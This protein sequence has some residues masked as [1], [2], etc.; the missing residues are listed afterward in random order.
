MKKLIYTFLLVFTVSVTSFA[1]LW[2]QG[3]ETNET[4]QF[5][6][7]MPNK[8]GIFSMNKNDLNNALSNAPYRFSNSQGVFVNFPVTISGDLEYFNVFRTKFL[9]DDLAAKYPDIKTYVGVN[10]ASGK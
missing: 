3:S 1:Q 5:N 4:K 2:K 9:E 7:I 6:E 8:Y 10:K